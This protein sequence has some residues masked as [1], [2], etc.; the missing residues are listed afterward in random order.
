MRS[1]NI[2]LQIITIVVSTLIL[3]ATTLYIPVVGAAPS[4][5]NSQSNNPLSLQPLPIQYT[6]DCSLSISPVLSTH[7]QTS[8]TDMDV[9][10]NVTMSN[11]M[12]S[13][14][15]NVLVHDIF[16]G[17]VSILS[18]VP[19]YS[20][21]GSEVAW[22]MGDFRPYESKNI[23]M[24]IK[25]DTSTTSSTTID[26]GF[27]VFG[28]L[29]GGPIYTYANGIVMLP[30]TFGEYLIN[31]VDAD[32]TDPYIIAQ[33]QILSNN[34]EE[35]FEFARDEVKYESYN[36]SLRG[37]RGTLWSMAGN[38][39]D[40]SSLLVAL[41]RANGIPARY[42]NG[43][44]SDERAKE[45]IA[46]MFVFPDNVIGSVPEGAETADPLN[47]TALMAEARNH[48]WVEY[49][50]DSEDQWTSLD[51]SF[52]GADMGES[53]TTADEQF[54][55][56]PDSLRHKVT[57]KLKVEKQR[58]TISYPLT[59]TMSTSGLYGKK[60]ALGH[61]VSI[62]EDCIYTMPV[63]GCIEMDTTI[64]YQPYLLIGD[65]K[66]Y[67]ASFQDYF[68]RTVPTWGTSQDITIQYTGEW[69][70][71]EVDDLTETSTH[72]RMIF[73]KIG[74]VNRKTGAAVTPDIN[75]SVS[76]V[77]I[78]GMVIAPGE[79]PSF[80]FGAEMF[81]LF[82]V[83]NEMN[84]TYSAIENKEWGEYT[85]EEKQLLVDFITGMT[86]IA[87]LKDGGASDF[88][89]DSLAD[90]YLTRAYFDSPRIIMASQVKYGD[91]VNFGID[92]RKNDIRSVLY[93]GQLTLAQH[94][95][96]QTRGI[97]E[98][99]IEGTVIEQL[100]NQ[101]VI[102]V[103]K[104][105]EAADEQ[106]ISV[107]MFMPATDS[108][109]DSLI[110]EITNLS[111][112]NEDKSLLI[113]SAEMTPTYNK[114]EIMN[115]N[116]SEEAKYRIIETLESGKGVIVPEE[117]VTVDGV[118]TIG[119]W[120]I[121]PETHEILG[122]MEN[123]LHW[124]WWP[125]IIGILIPIFLDCII[126]IYALVLNLK[127]VNNIHITSEGEV[128]SKLGLEEAKQKSVNDI[129]IF[130]E[131]AKDSTLLMGL[132]VADVIM[133]SIPML[134][135]DTLIYHWL[136]G[137]LPTLKFVAVYFLQFCMGVIIYEHAIKNFVFGILADPPPFAN[138]NFA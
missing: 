84:E 78:F 7:I 20:L 74:Y 76:P 61:D 87:A 70:E 31:T 85:D 52:E 8:D 9:W 16:T 122:V 100:T 94:S 58:S 114:T 18:S 133:K 134:A 53:F 77:D 54:V 104:I 25:V 34:P 119:W 38:S 130:H 102:S 99:S 66:I 137:L 5:G 45:L 88:T 32:I 80:A 1:T 120:E 135:K 47:D 4:G 98:A 110:D 138:V 123:G 67:G 42:V 2:S 17:N 111:I 43:T 15:E 79:V 126:F 64:T 62:S 21:N 14:L 115:M 68:K 49:Y 60:I 92:L 28:T 113:S 22:S 3:T 36:G 19:L 93:P 103:P 11:L 97:S 131:F 90:F 109:I 95:F 128:K 105:F 27:S 40:Q 129:K 86:Y 41:L 101:S 13:T 121:N 26:S 63:V 65:E 106:N 73:D 71:F 117:M 127:Y 124:S 107:R 112:S 51:P 118:I 50:S 69:L 24:K 56:I 136:K 96:M 83:F 44:L 33:A 57:F 81:E 59:Y 91:K 12:N 48:T 72:E 132:V 108:D 39:M 89:T 116:I 46:S 37:A 30:S 10:L 125:I 23:T 55:E 82:P 29:N 6:Y 35:I 75:I